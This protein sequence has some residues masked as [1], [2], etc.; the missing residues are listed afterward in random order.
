M[1][2]KIVVFSCF[3]ISNVSK[4][5]KWPKTIK[6]ILSCSA[7]CILTMFLYVILFTVQLWFYQTGVVQN[8]LVYSCSC[9]EPKLKARLVM[10]FYLLFK[11][12]SVIIASKRNNGDFPRY[13]FDTTISPKVTRLRGEGSRES[14]GKPG[15]SAIVTPPP[16]NPFLTPWSRYC[17]RSPG[18]SVERGGGN[19]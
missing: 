5:T 6:K 9:F 7:F 10:D 15:L 4:L 19:I 1:L 8:N 3:R 16:H 17:T 2:Y 18:V 11:T 13:Q 14:Y 12:I